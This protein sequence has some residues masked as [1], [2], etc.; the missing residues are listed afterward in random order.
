MAWKEMG[1]LED[2]PREDLA[3]EAAAIPWV[4]LTAKVL[5]VEANEE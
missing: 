1:F 4:E 5:G 3:R 2:T